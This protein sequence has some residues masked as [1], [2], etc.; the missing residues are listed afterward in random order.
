V[1]EIYFRNIYKF[2][3][4]ISNDLGVAVKQPRLALGSATTGNSLFNSSE[5]F[6]N[7]KI[8]IFLVHQI[9][10][11]QRV[12]KLNKIQFGMYL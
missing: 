11:E 4:F 5:T 12:L 3:Y 7:Y 1:S 10:I 2:I 6:C 8:F 9:H